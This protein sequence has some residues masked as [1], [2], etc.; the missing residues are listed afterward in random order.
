MHSRILNG[1]RLIPGLQEG[2]RALRQ[3]AHQRGLEKTQHAVLSDD[4]YEILVVLGMRRSGNHVA[5]NWILEQVDGPAVFYNNIDSQKAP[6]TA[7]RTEFRTRKG[8][9][10]RLIL[11]Y[12]DVS[13]DQLL[14]DPLISFLETRQKEDGARVRFALILR[15]PYNLFASRLRKWPERFSTDTK[16]ASQIAL[17]NELAGLAANPAPI[18][19][20]AP[21]IPILFNSLISDDDYRRHIASSFGVKEGD[22]GLDKVPVYGHGSSFDGTTLTGES[23]RDHVFER[24]RAVEN[25]PRFQTILR[26]PEV[27]EIGNGLFQMKPPLTHKP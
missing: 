2:V 23:V 14:S 12:E 6:Y 25:E 19:N 17:Y 1:L 8:K 16:I 11:S 9:S 7:G 13:V 5:I 15:D 27:Q 21:L 24:W 20:D 3:R 10:P 18:W 4:G 22:V 26:S